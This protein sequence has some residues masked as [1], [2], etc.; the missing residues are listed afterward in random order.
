MIN[1]GDGPFRGKMGRDII[2]SELRL[3]RVVNITVE[4]NEVDVLDRN[5]SAAKVPQ[6]IIIPGLEERFH[7]ETMY[8]V[9]GKLYGWTLSRAWYYWAA[10]CERLE[11][12]VGE[13]DAMI[14]Y[15]RFKQDLR[16]DGHCGCPPPTG[17]HLHYHCRVGV[18]R[19][20]GGHDL[21]VD[22][23]H[24]TFVEKSADWTVLFRDLDQQNPGKR[25]GVNLYHIDSQDAL[26]ALCAYLRQRG[27]RRHAI[28]V[29]AHEAA[30]ARE[31]WGYQPT[32]PIDGYLTL[33]KGGIIDFTNPVS[34]ERKE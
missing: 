24:V 28:E 30:M 31:E 15:E 4:E 34:E 10:S 32:S 6:G 2:L 29:A 22:G 13:K 27:V 21:S 12:E 9:E 1:L 26:D 17:N 20:E 7:K 11:D 33:N 25:V 19:V 3:A 18:K 16:V 14:L 5:C 23:K 8:R